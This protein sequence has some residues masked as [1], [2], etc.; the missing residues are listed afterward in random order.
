M[1]A[2]DAYSGTCDWCYEHCQVCEWD[3]DD[4]FVVDKGDELCRFCLCW[5]GPPPEL[6]PQ[7]HIRSGTSAT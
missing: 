6:V 7:R 5:P 3:E 2:W 4:W 1:S